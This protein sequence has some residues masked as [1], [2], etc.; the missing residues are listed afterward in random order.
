MA[1]YVEVKDRLKAFYARYPDGRIQSEIIPELTRLKEVVHE[2]V[3]GERGPKHTRFGIGMV[4]VKAYAYRTPD[5]QRPATGMSGMLMP[6]TTPYTE[7]SELENAET[8][9]WGRALANLDILNYAGIASRDEVSKARQDD[10]EAEIAAA[11]AF[12]AAQQPDSA[13]SSHRGGT[14]LKVNGQQGPE[15]GTDTPETTEAKGEAP[16]ALTPAEFL[17]LVRE[18]HV[19]SAVINRIRI[20]LFDESRKMADLS[21]EQRGALWAAIMAERKEQ[22]REGAAGG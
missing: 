14:S 12:E 10:V 8:S 22:D 13:S 2:I 20:G 5:D 18:N 16:S 4:A 17:S 11:E 7:G 6:G 15:T 1:G 21:D 19:F 3:Q 9:A